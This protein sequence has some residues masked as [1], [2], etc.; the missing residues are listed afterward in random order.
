MQGQGVPVCRAQLL[1][2]LRIG[3]HSLLSLCT[4]T[5][6]TAH[7]DREG[8]R[9]GREELD[10]RVLSAVEHLGIEVVSVEVHRGSSGGAEEGG[11][12]EGS[13]L[14]RHPWRRKIRLDALANNSTAAAT[15]QRVR[16]TWAHG[17][18]LPKP[19]HAPLYCRRS[20]G[21]LRGLSPFVH[22][23]TRQRAGAPQF[24]S[25]SRMH[26]AGPHCGT[27]TGAC[28]H[29]PWGPRPCRPWGSRRGSARPAYH[30]SFGYA[31]P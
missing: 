22:L 29:G 11:Q 15:P 2:L 4:R 24:G 27:G 12:A 16:P 31:G 14:A 30:V 21:L 10:E 17:T 5:G 25:K 20:R 6:Q 18:P 3:D 8:E 28:G 19:P 9:P 7:A 1:L 13:I 23:A 26:R